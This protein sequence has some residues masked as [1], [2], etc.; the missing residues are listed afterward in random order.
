MKIPDFRTSNKAILC[1][2]IIDFTEHWAIKHLVIPLFIIGPLS[3]LFIVLSDSELLSKMDELIGPSVMGFLKQ[4]QLISIIVVYVSI[5]L[6]QSL[7]VFINHC[8]K[9]DSVLN[10]DNILSII[11]S[12]DFVV[13]AKK[14]RFL[15]ET[16]KALIEN[17]DKPTIFNK[18]TQPEQQIA[19]LVCAIKAHFEHRL[20]YK[21]EFR[22]GLMR[23]KEGGLVDWFA[24]A[25][26]THPPRTGVDVLSSPSSTIMRALTTQG[27]VIV[28]DIQKELK[29]PSK[30]Q[31]KFVKGNT[32]PHNN[33]SVLAVPVYCPNTR[34]PIYVLSILGNRQNCLQECHRELYEWILDHFQSRLIIEHHLYLLKEGSI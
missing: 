26:T 7:K 6:F 30:N 16:K 10:R 9:P 12:V 20:K 8:A 25:P 14:D 17:W 4:S 2:K 23:V 11:E 19:L 22:V 15:Q 5:H 21:V 32:Q 29:K 33:G 31:R 13:T 27:M 28:Q 3:I 34:K 18:I 24:F 1:S